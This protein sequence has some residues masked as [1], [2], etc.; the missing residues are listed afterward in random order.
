MNK[1]FISLAFAAFMLFASCSSPSDSSSSDLCTKAITKE[2]LAGKWHL[3]K[4]VKGTA[5][6]SECTPKE[7]TNELKL[8]KDGSFEFKG[9]YSVY[10]ETYGTFELDEN[11]TTMTINAS[12]D[13]EYNLSATL[14]I[15]SSGEELRITSKDDYSSFLQCGAVNATEVFY[16][17]GKR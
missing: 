17:Q 14:E 16:W 1:F 12:G 4:V 9:G 6:I 10:T 5:A 15:R 2:C 13:Y 11:G 8:N 7:G 3:E